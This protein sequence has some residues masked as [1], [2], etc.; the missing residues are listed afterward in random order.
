MLKVLVVEDSQARIDQFIQ[1]LSEIGSPVYHIAKTSKEALQFLASNKYDLIFLDHDLDYLP[2]ED[3]DDNAMPI[4]RYLRDNP[5]N[6]HIIVHSLNDPGSENL[7]NTIG[8]AALRVQYVWEHD[9]FHRTI[10]I[11]VECVGEC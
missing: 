1:R 4:A 8:G 3:R 10:K 6:C 11:N 7:L 9:V 5:V 2:D